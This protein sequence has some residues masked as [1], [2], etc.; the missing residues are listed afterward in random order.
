ME[1]YID[2]TPIKKNLLQFPDVA[3]EYGWA[4]KIRQRDSPL[5]ENMTWQYR[6]VIVG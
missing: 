2:G 4:L 6:F 5:T 1:E 3:V